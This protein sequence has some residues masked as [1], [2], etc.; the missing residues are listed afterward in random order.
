MEAIEECTPLDSLFLLKEECY[1]YFSKLE[2]WLSEN[3]ESM[4][5]KEQIV[6]N[7]INQIKKNKEDKKLADP[8]QSFPISSSQIMPTPIKFQ[9]L[10]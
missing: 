6:V 2:D 10:S 3:T 7:C 5:K 1:R 4:A 9:N 8:F